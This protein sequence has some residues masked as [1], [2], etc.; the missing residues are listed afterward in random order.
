MR[1]SARQLSTI[2]RPVAARD[3]HHARAEAQFRSQRQP[4]LLEAQELV[5]EQE[6]R[7]LAFFGSAATRAQPAG[8]E[9]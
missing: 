2:A 3:E 4:R 5:V 9:K 8:V 1:R 7:G 6:Q